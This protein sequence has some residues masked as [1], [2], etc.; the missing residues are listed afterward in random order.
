MKSLV[1]GFKGLVASRREAGGLT[2]DA[3]YWRARYSA[4]GSSGTGSEGQNLAFKGNF[5]STFIR[6]NQVDTVLD[7][8]C[9]QGAIIPFLSNV[10]YL[11]VDFAEPAVRYCVARW[12]ETEKRKFRHVHRVQSLST[13]SD[14]VLLLE[15]LMH[16]TDDEEYRTLLETCFSLAKRFVIIQSPLIA[17]LGRKEKRPPHEKYRD[18]LVSLIPYYPNFEVLQVHFAPEMTIEKRLAGEIGSLASDFL[19]MKRKVG[20]NPNASSEQ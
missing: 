4:G 16:V 18:L 19:V 10:E 8:G 15:V 12:G 14:A 7:V 20:G 17:D 11:G 3:N 1:K 13:S 9:G 5:V 2:D 6:E